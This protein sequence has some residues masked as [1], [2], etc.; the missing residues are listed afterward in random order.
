[1]QAIKDLAQILGLSGACRA[2]G[3]PR[4]YVYRARRAAVEPAVSQPVRP[5]PASPRALSEEERAKVLDLLNSERFQ[6]Q[7]PGEVYAA[8][9]DEGQYMCSVRTMYRILDDNDEVQERRDQ[10][11]HPPRVKPRLV[12][13]G[14]NQVWS[15]D[16][17]KLRSTHKGV[18][19]YLYTIIDI[20]SRYVVGWMIAERESADLAEQLIDETCARHGITPGQ[21]TLHADRGAPM[22]AQTVVML[23]AHLGVTESHSRPHVSNDNPFSEAIFKTVKYH[24]Q[25]PGEFG[26]AVDVR[27]WG[28]E[29]FPWYNEEHHHTGLA[30]LTPADVHFG[31][32]RTILARRQAVLAQAYAAH[33]ERFVNGKPQPLQPPSEVWINRPSVDAPD[34][35][36]PDRGLPSVDRG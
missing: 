1:M 31:R 28:R 30:L 33:P 21:L 10:L 26:S 24:A 18:Y 17:T 4:S 35:Q 22:T 23:M 27:A 14:P 8:L 20:F 13:T 25:Y 36:E 34:A 5:R 32:T 11:R 12:A 29:F 3:V 6:D 19:Y 9:L 2:L 7:A 16:I 15:W